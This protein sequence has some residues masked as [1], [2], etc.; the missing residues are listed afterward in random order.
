MVH[1]S[2]YNFTAFDRMILFLWSIRVFNKL[3]KV[4]KLS[5]LRLFEAKL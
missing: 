3:P 2:F 4:I 5:F 1:G